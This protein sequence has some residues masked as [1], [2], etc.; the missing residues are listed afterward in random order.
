MNYE[1]DMK[2]DESALDVEWLNQS[3][4][5][6]KY[7]KLCAKAH[8]DM[9][10][11]QEKLNLVKFDLDYKIRL[12]P[13]DYGISLDVKITE[14]VI[15]GTT[16]QQDEYQEANKQFLLRRYEYETIKGAVT[17]VEH[18]KT[19]LENLVKLF[20]QQYFAGPSVPRDLSKEWIKRQTQESVDAGVSDKLNRIK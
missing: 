15:L 7:A 8:L 13:K 17:A 19:S 14:A 5:M 9:D 2:I 1:E 4:L 10:L 12:N 6:I 20:G 16:L 11:E 3:S 18:R